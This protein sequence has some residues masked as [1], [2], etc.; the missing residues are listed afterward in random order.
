MFQEI[1]IVIG[2][3]I[4]SVTAVEL[5]NLNSLCDG[6][7]NLLIPLMKRRQEDCSKLKRTCNT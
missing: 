6:I 2:F 4:D 5:W 1:K 7:Y 3:T